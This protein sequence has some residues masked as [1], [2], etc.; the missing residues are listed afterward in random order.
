VDAERRDGHLDDECRRPEGAPMRRGL[1]TAGIATGIAVGVVLAD[2]RF[3]RPWEETWNATEAEVEGDLPGDDLAP[4]PTTQATRAITIDATPDDVWP[5][6]LQLGADRGGFYSYDWL[7][8]LFGLG[9][10][11]ASE[12]VPA[13]QDLDAG[14]LVYANRSRTGGWLVVQAV[15]PEVLVMKVA[16]VDE[17]R[18]I[19]RDEGPGWEFQW[20][21]ALRPVD[22]GHTRLIVR[23]RVAFERRATRWLMAPLGP[24]SFVMTR[25]MLKGIKRRAEQ[26][27]P[28]QS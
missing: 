2:Q 7:E 3:L 16:D 28:H 26:A 10:H 6:L 8:D 22:G 1:A 27:S 23:E 14:D 24:V 9:I 20:T 19:R 15:R 25:K 18:A 12:V 17:R 13:W 4:A 11:S 5:W 21:F